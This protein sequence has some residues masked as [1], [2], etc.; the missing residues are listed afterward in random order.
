MGVLERL[1]RVRRLFLQ[2]VRERQVAAPAE[3]VLDR[4]GDDVVEGGAEADRIG[5]AGLELAQHPLEDALG[6]LVGVRVGSD[7]R[8]AAAA[9]LLEV[10]RE[11][12]AVLAGLEQLCVFPVARG[13][14]RRE[15]FARHGAILRRSSGTST[16][17]PPPCGDDGCC[18]PWN[19]A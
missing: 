4:P 18:M 14:H 11:Q 10:A 8:A 15:V 16:D 12:P 5:L 6:D 13:I 19:R 7:R 2:P 1:E 9:D 17:G 3:E